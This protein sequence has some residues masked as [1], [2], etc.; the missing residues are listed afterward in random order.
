MAAVQRGTPGLG[1]AALLVVVVALA[2]GVVEV[3]AVAPAGVEP[4]GVTVTVLVEP[5]HEHSAS[6][7]SVASNARIWIVLVIVS[8]RVS[9][10]VTTDPDAHHRSPLRVIADDLARHDSV[11]GP[12]L[13]VAA[14]ILL[15]LSL[16]Q[17]LTIGPSWLLPVVEGVLLIGLLVASPMPQV[18]HSP[19]RRRIAIALIGVVSAVNIFSLVE[20]CHYLLQGRRE[21]GHALILAGMVLWVTNVLLFALWYWELDRGGPVQ[22][23]RG[24]D[25][26]P[27]FLFPQMSTPKHAP[28]GWT[29]GLIDYLYVSFTNAS[30]FSPTDTM[31]LTPS[32][33]SLMGTQALAA[34]ITVGLVVARAVN[35]LS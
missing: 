32:A 5:P 27:D 35:I 18:R 21:S 34:L 30:A 20:L 17:K 2:A 22:R 24:S 6:P 4:L 19:L 26:A 29:P 11:L 25:A 13:V 31:P 33:K 23:A 14:A 1:A 12:Q 28:A 3:V 9:Q 15:D 7:A 10:P 16:P 8:L